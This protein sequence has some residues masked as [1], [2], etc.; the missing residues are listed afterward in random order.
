LLSNRELDEADDAD[1]MPEDEEDEDEE[2][3]GEADEP[4]VEFGDELDKMDDDPAPDK[5]C[6]EAEKSLPVL[7]LDDANVLPCKQF[8]CRNGQKSEAKNG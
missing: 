7:L 6:E 1:E 3:D 5:H 8:C 4:E 2:A